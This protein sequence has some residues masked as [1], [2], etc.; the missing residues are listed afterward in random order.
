MRAQ[1]LRKPGLSRFACIIVA[2]TAL[3]WIGVAPSTGIMPDPSDAAPVDEA[4]A[5]VRIVRFDLSQYESLPAAAQQMIDPLMDPCSVDREPDGRRLAVM[6]LNPDAIASLQAAGVQLEDRGSMIDQMRR[7]APLNTIRRGGLPAYEALL[8]A[9]APE[10]D[11]RG[12]GGDVCLDNL[13]SLFPYDVY[14]SYDES[15]C[16][17]DNLEAAFPAIAKVFIIG[18]SVQGRDI[19]ALKI[20]DNPSMNE[21]DEEAI[22][23]SGVTHAREWVTHEMVLYIAEW[24]TSRYAFDPRVQNIVNNSVVWLVPI[25]NPDGLTVSRSAPGFRLWRKNNRV[26]AD[27]GCFCPNYPDCWNGVDLNRNYEE[28]WGLDNSGS[29]GDLCSGVYRGPSPASEPETQAI[30]NLLLIQRPAISV[31]FHS[32]GQ[33]FLYPWGHTRFNIP[34]S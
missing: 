3:S 27:P 19:C 34:E 8:G 22:F 18:Q 5:A 23:F 2:A 25:V 15:K 4:L 29:S 13:T 32:Y 28:K 16:F 20:S 33:M 7:F 12:G 6:F 31:S 30:Q 1:H 10:F 14:H 24:L 21:S 26:N 11:P 9:D 17:L